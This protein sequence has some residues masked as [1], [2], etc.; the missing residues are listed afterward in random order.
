[1]KWKQ[2]I[3]NLKAKPL[4]APK[5]VLAATSAPVLFV[6]ATGRQCRYPLWDDAT[7]AEKQM[8]CGAPATE[9]T[10]WCVGH[11]KAVF[12]NYPRPDRRGTAHGPQMDGEA[13]AMT[14]ST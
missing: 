12:A 10:S 1:M 13:S 8:V 14:N 7:P 5:P 2:N 4:F 11:S 3:M 6:D 9:G